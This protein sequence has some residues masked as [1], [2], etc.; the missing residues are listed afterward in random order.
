MTPR[1][2]EAWGLMARGFTNSEI[3]RTMEVNRKTVET[4]VGFIYQYLNIQSGH[5]GR[6]KA[7]LAYQREYPPERLKASLE[8]CDLAREALLKAL[9]S[10]GG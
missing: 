2:V 1:A 7:A 10:C 9:E 5:A 4:Y 8:Q 6:V 3:A